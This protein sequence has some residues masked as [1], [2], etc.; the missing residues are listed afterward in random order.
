MFYVD[1]HRA[2]FIIPAHP[3]QANMH[4]QYLDLNS[5]FNFKPVSPSLQFSL[6]C[7]LSHVAPSS[8]FSLYLFTVSKLCKH[9]SLD[10]WFAGKLFI[11]N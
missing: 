6:V 5:K 3:V 1:V 10:C 11:L 4:A 7:G 9:Q 8:L 2:S